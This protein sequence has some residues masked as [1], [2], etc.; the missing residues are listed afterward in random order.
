[1]GCFALRMTPRQPAGQAARLHVVVADDEPAIR[2]ALRLLFEQALGLDFVEELTCAAALPGLCSARGMP[3]DL[4]LVDW[5]LPGL[6]PAWLVTLHGASSA[7]KI[8]ALSGRP[9]A[10]P[11]ALAAGAD[12][13]LYRGAP[14]EQ[15]LTTLRS[16]V[17]R[18]DT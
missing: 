11:E 2:S 3:P 15:L 9:E 14:P 12:A 17:G 18:G 5:E 7:L 1:M 4:L 10:G 16:L 8:V 13:F 6:D